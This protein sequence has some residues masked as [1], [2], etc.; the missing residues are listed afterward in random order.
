MQQVGSHADGVVAVK[1]FVSGAT[2]VIGR[3]TIPHLIAAGHEV[4]AMARSPAKADA[5]KKIGARPAIADLFDT[6]ALREA[7]AGHEAVINVATRIPSFSS[8]GAFLP[9]AWAENDRVRKIGS[10]NLVD[11]SLAGGVRVFAQES[12]APAYPDC[13]DRWIDET[14]ALEPARYNR[15]LVDAERSAQRFT[16]RVGT[17][18]VLRFGAFYGPDAAQIASLIQWIRRGWAP[19]PAVY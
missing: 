13:G 2:G 5:L 8:L 11:A 1:I 7:V 15:T 10:A 4:T 12:F 6:P 14:V 17:G 9:G 16:E 19:I 3:R 18:I